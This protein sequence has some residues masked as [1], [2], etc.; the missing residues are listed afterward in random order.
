V[1][2]FFQVFKGADFAGSFNHRYKNPCG[3]PCLITYGA[4]AKGPVYIFYLAV[5]I[6]GYQQVLIPY[7]IGMI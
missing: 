6:Y 7:G 1:F 3:L 2:T 5:P 4:I